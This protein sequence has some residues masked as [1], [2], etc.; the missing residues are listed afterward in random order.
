MG[1]PFLADSRGS[2]SPV[3]AKTHAHWMIA[4]SADPFPPKAIVQFE[5][6]MRLMV[7]ERMRGERI[8]NP[9]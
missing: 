6:G 7:E 4:T 8:D 9:S 1:L 3:H 2:V 5:S